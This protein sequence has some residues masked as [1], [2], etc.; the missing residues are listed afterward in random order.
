M[1]VLVRGPDWF[2]KFWQSDFDPFFGFLDKI[3]D[4]MDV[5]VARGTLEAVL[6]LAELWK[7]IYIRL[8]MKL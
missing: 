2:Q 6:G 3:W 5:K 7:L 8:Y 1:S 4:N